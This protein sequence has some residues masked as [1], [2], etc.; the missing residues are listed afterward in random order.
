MHNKVIGLF[1]FSECTISAIV[2]LDMME[3]YASPQLEEFQPWTVLQQDGSPPHWGL[4]V[5]Q[6]LEHRL[7]LF[8]NKVL[9]RIFGPKRDEVTG[10]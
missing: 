3:F 7:R 9:R 1:L 10:G 8:E 4:L 2:Y 6:F 5:L